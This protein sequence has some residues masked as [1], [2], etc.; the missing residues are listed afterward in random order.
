MKDLCAIVIKYIT[1]YGELNFVDVSSLV[2]YDLE[3][4]PP[5]SFREF[6][7]NAVAVINEISRKLEY[8]ECVIVF[9]GLLNSHLLN[10]KLMIAITAVNCELDTKTQNWLKQSI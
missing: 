4:L 3:Q 5:S 2:N 7:L 8:T 9:P 1:I 6:L 10:G